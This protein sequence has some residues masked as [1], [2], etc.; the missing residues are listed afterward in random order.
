M[1]YT[2]CTINLNSNSLVV[3]GQMFAGGVNFNSNSDLTFDAIDVPNVGASRFDED[4]Q[5]IREI[6]TD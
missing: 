2:P 6:V 4:I 3:E 5:Y 1:L